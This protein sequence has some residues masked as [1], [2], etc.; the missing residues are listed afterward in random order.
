MTVRSSKRTSL[1]ARRGC[2]RWLVA[3]VIAL[4]ATNTRG[5]APSAHPE[6]ASGNAGVA[7]GVPAG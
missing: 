5:H 3:M 7:V 1:S 4:R 6:I 2:T